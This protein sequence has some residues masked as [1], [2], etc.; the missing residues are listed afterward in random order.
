MDKV[1]KLLPSEAFII[2]TA[3][4]CYLDKQKSILDDMEDYLFEVPMKEEELTKY[5]ENETEQK[6]FIE[7]IKNLKK[8]IGEL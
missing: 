4:D 7:K 5:L 2:E 8:K 1:F 3:L 6:R